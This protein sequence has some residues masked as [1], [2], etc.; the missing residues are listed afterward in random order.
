MRE[1][2]LKYSD[3]GYPVMSTNM[4]VERL[5][6]VKVRGHLSCAAYGK[7][8]KEAVEGQ[9]AAVEGVIR[10]GEKEGKE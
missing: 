3:F 1:R 7:S 6:P 4:K 9:P 5:L 2:R 10:K 8:S